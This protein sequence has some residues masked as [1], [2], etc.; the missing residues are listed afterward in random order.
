M[1]IW[2]EGI[3]VAPESEIQN[4]ASEPHSGIQLKS[5]S[6][7][8][9]LPFLT[10]MENRNFTYVAAIIHRRESLCFITSDM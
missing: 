7:L 2:S 3:A 1:W 9:S 6:S 4:A 8:S 5:M 10:T